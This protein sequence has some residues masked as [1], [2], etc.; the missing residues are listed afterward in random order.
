MIHGMNMHLEDAIIALS[1]RIMFLSNGKIGQEGPSIVMEDL[2]HWLEFMISADFLLE[3]P[4]VSFLMCTLEIL[5]NLFVVQVLA[6][7]FLL[8]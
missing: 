4:Q 7:N 6:L 2:E 3:A 5:Q 8:S 1:L